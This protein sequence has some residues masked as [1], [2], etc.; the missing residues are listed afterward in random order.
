MPTCIAYGCSNTAKKSDIKRGFFQVPFPKNE[1]GKKHAARWLHNIGT[2]YTVQTF[3]F[4][5]GK[6]VCEDHFH[7]DCFERNLQAELL[8]YKAKRKLR[9]GA[10]P[11]IFKH[12][13]FDQINMDGTVLSSRVGSAKRIK[14]L[15]DNTVS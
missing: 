7:P 12:Q 2:G 10:V 9:P 13:V 11:T 8:N 3:R 1:E 14:R 6:K 4:T 5:E 15:E